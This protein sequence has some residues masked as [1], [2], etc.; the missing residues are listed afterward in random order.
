MKKK[1]LNQNTPKPERAERWVTTS[2]DDSVWTPCWEGNRLKLHV[3]I[4]YFRQW[5][6][7]IAA[8]G[9]DDFGVERVYYFG[10]DYKKA[11]E[12]YNKLLGEMNS[13]PDGVNLEWFLAH[14]YEQF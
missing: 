3:S 12:K 11:K 6:V 2:D 4:M 8:W 13:I 14:G 5:Y 9:A 7:K 1:N 10:E